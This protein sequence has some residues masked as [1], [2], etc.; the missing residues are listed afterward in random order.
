[1]AKRQS[2]TPAAAVESTVEQV[3]TIENSNVTADHL[4]PKDLAAIG[5]L[6]AL[7]LRAGVS[8]PD[9]QVEVLAKLVKPIKAARGV[10]QYSRGP[11]A[12]LATV[13]ADIKIPLQMRVI[14]ENLDANMDMPTW[15]AAVS[16]DKRWSS[17]QSIE[18]VIRFYRPKMIEL[19]LIELV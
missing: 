3:A 13:D 17:T 19:G 14:V 9:E 4:D 15:C 8:L 5:I 10:A 12:Q 11:A 16:T 18:S 2:A 1:M 7:L 6:Q